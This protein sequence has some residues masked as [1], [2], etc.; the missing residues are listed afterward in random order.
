MKATVDATN[1]V[2]FSVVLTAETAEESV[3]LNMLYRRLLARHIPGVSIKNCGQS[4]IR[5]A[6]TLDT[7]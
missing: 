4:D 1:G 2:R 6:L 5:Y 3:C 7:I